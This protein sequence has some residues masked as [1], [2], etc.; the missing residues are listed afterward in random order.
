MVLMV[1]Q[2][3]WRCPHWAVTTC[4]TLS[5]QVDGV[6]TVTCLLQVAYSAGVGAALSRAPASWNRVPALVWRLAGFP[7]SSTEFAAFNETHSRIFPKVHRISARQGMAGDCTRDLPSVQSKTTY[8]R[9][10]LRSPAGITQE[11]QL[12]VARILVDVS[13][14]IV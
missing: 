9:Q 10:P 2:S 3:V 8:V 14:V 7:I 12:S 6:R 1:W 4:T 5:N 11:P 13:R